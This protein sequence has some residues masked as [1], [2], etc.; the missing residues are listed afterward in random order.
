M[1]A[2][3]GLVRDSHENDDEGDPLTMVDIHGGVM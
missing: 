2:C 3:N 1:L